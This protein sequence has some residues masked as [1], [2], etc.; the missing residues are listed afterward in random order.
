MQNSHRLY[1]RNFDFTE[2]LSKTRVS[3]SPYWFHEFRE[4]IKNDESMK[5]KRKE[6]QFFV[7]SVTRKFR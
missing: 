3:K 6:T 4:T 5:P 7:A 1:H 2:F